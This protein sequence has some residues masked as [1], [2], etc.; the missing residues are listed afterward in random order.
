P[1]SS[2]LQRMPET[3]FRSFWMGGFEGADH[4]NGSG[5]AL[6]MAASNEHIARLDEDYGAAVRQGIRTVRESLGWRL[7][8]PKDGCFDWRRLHA[9]RAAAERNGVQVLWTLM[10][11]GT[12]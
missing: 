2:A 3:P 1:G 8:E 9:I 7:S 11:Y 12:P 6:D 4:R 5:V 10:H